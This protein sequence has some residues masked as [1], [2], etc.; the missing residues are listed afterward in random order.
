MGTN[1]IHEGSILKTNYLSKALPPN[2]TTLDLISTHEFLGN[3]NIRLV[4]TFY[5]PFT[6]SWMFELLLLFGFYEQFCYEY[7]LLSF[8]LT[9]VFISLHIY[10]GLELLDHVVSGCLNF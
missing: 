4:F 9:N 6:W 5:L 10:L 8:V 1:L 2:T 3:I 7:L